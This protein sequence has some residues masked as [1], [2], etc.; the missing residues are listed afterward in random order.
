MGEGQGGDGGERLFVLVCNLMKSGHMKNPNKI[1]PSENSLNFSQSPEGTLLIQIKG[2]WKIG[3]PLPSADEVE[4]KLTAG[5]RVK[6]VE[7]DTSELKAWDSGLS[8]LPH[9]GEGILLPE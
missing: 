4:K 6:R 5:A 7:F 1:A 2:D 3:N 8:D 9:Q